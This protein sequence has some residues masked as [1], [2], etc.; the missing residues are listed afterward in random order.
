M[1]N[2][3]KNL[4]KKII[5]TLI[6]AAFP[7]IGVIIPLIIHITTFKPVLTE[8][9]AERLLT[10]LIPYDNWQNTLVSAS[11]RNYVIYAVLFVICTTA[12][13]AFALPLLITK[14]SNSKKNSGENNGKKE[15]KIPGII[16]LA[17]LMVTGFA[18][19]YFAIVGH[20]N[21]I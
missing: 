16:I 19:G 8:K 14:L 15:N 7:L 13:S 4:T 3:E 17:C 12:L 21:L 11:I 6:N 5:K 1:A 18:V 10:T 2:S 20:Y 9:I